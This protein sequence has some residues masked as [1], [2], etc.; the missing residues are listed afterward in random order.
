M[1]D[2]KIT[3][4]VSTETM[5]KFT[6]TGTTGHTHYVTGSFNNWTFGDMETD[7]EYPDVKVFYF[8]IG[9]HGREEF[10]IILDQNLNMRMYPANHCEAPGAGLPYGPDRK[11]KGKNWEVAGPPGQEMEIRLD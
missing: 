5:G 4:T 8:K 2:G 6:W 1:G 9:K 3:V 7:E 10:Q 11:G